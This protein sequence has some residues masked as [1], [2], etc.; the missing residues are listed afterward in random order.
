LKW[1][2]QIEQLRAEN[3]VRQNEFLALYA[4]AEKMLEENGGS[5]QLDEIATLIVDARAKEIEG[6]IINAHISGLVAKKFYDFET[7]S[8]LHQY[9]PDIYLGSAL[10]AKQRPELIKQ[11][12]E[13]SFANEKILDHSIETEIQIEPIK[14][15]LKAQRDGLEATNLKKELL[16][17]QIKW[18][19]QEAHWYLRQ[20]SLFYKLKAAYGHLQHER[21]AYHGYQIRFGM[22]QV[23]EDLRPRIQY[24]IKL[25]MKYQQ[26][27]AQ[28][29]KDEK[30][31]GALSKMLK[32]F[33]GKNE[34]DSDGQE[35]NIFEQAEKLGF[36]I[37]KEKTVNRVRQL[38]GKFFD[39]AK[40]DTLIKLVQD[41][42]FYRNRSI[43]GEIQNLARSNALPM[44]SRDLNEM[45][46]YEDRKTVH[47][48]IYSEGRGTKVIY[49]SGYHDG[50][51]HESYGLMNPIMMDQ[52]K[53]YK[54]PTGKGFIRYLSS[55][56][57]DNM[58]VDYFEVTDL[59][60]EN[61]NAVETRR[62]L[63]ELYQLGITDGSSHNVTYDT[64][65]LEYIRNNFKDKEY[66]LLWKAYSQMLAVDGVMTEPTKSGK[67][68]VYLPG[69]SPNS[70]LLY[71]TLYSLKIRDQADAAKA[72]LALSSRQDL[73]LS[74]LEILPNASTR[75]GSDGDVGAGFIAEVR[76]GP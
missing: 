36:D 39:T 25:K 4:K 57:Q 20:Q 23:I 53:T 21:R 61:S 27:L 26:E 6:L 56:G 7:S 15:K 16:L 60:V 33:A 45:G 74:R 22:K 31:P 1:E 73:V 66:D 72:I 75:V 9:K 42:D 52:G 71:G 63:K 41:L 48:Q 18:A 24:F 70:L 51:P 50:R 35:T 17:L 62:H 49:S 3:Q 11:I 76:V 64:R 43:R 10:E 59:D 65:I 55:S 5:T 12:F 68:I 54:L 2:L 13:N 58:R 37:V 14:N 32:F 47:F 28:L 69:S 46:L 29:D 19:D 34:E 40:I 30:P 38:I 67:E 8:D 44:T